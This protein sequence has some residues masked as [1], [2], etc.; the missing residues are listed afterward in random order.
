MPRP[1][2]HP[3]AAA[4][5]PPASAGNHRRAC[6]HEINKTVQRASQMTRQLL[7]FS[8]R[9]A[10]CRE[11]TELN[12]FVA[13][14]VQ[15]IRRLI[16]ESIALQ[17][18][19]APAPL[20]IQVDRG[21]LEQVLLNLCLNARDAMPKGGT[22]SIRIDS[23][24]LDGA[25]AEQRRLPAGNEYVRLIFSDTGHGMDKT[26]LT[27]IFDPF[28][29]TKAR[30]KGTGLGLAV[31]YGIVRQ[32]EG[33]IEVAS[34]PGRGAQ[35]T[36]LLPRRHEADAPRDRPPEAVTAPAHAGGAILLAEDN[37]PIRR[38]AVTTLE[39]AGYCVQAG[40]DGR[41]AVDCFKRDPAGFDLLFFD[42]MMPNLGGFE[43][44]QQCRQLRPDIPVIFASG[45]A[46]DSV[47]QGESIPE[48]AH[49]LQK[50]YRAESLLQLV[51]QLLA[52][53]RG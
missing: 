15:M 9:Q 37:E 43:A 52:A 35:F 53:R 50:P 11:E 4:T 14:H 46:A 41:S 30:D 16:P 20:S 13:D 1:L 6:L 40:A 42:V 17:L 3:I 38:I 10:L 28:F 48:G 8:R 39:R 44:A 26:V 33:H 19:P 5:H 24:M 21:Q 34:E 49:L 18:E 2:H 22:L 7:A 47:D 32:H 45:Y 36:I 23:I 31:V 25:A 29:T 12:A 27:R 51:A